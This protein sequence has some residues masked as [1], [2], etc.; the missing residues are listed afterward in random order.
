MEYKDTNKLC[1]EL[2]KH[3][4]CPT[5]KKSQQSFHLKQIE[6]RS[7]KKKKINK[8]QKTEAKLKL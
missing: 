8:K 6:R 1:E 2:K 4:L 3:V 7:Q 5:K